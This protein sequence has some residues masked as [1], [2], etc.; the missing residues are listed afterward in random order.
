MSVSWNTVALAALGS[1]LSIGTPVSSVP[2]QTT[3]DRVD[4]TAD[5]WDL[6]HATIVDHLGR[7]AL[8]GTAF[9]KGVELDDGVIECDV[10]MKAD[11]RAYPGVLFRVQSPGE[12]ERVYLRP[13]RAPL[14]DDAVQYV[15]AFNGVD[16]WQLSNGPGRTASAVIPTGRWLHFRIEVLGTQARVYLD[17]SPEPVL[18][19][20]DLGH[21]KSR[22]G[23]GLTTAA[24][25]TAFFSNFSYRRDAALR[26]PPAP[27]IHTP[28]GIVTDWAVSAPFKRKRLDFDRYPEASVLRDTRWTKTT[29]RSDGIL[30][31]SRVQG[32]LGAEPDGILARTTIRA[33]QAGPRKY[34]FGYSDEAGIFLNGQLVFHG[35]SAYRSRDTSFLGI[36]GPF[37]AVSLP[38]RK[39]DNEVLFAIG[40]A[41]GGW[42]LTLQD[43]TAV[44]MARGVERMW[45]TPADFLVPESVA[46]DPG[47]NAFY[48]SNFDAYN[49]SRG[50]PRQAISKVTPDGHVEALEWVSGLFNPTGLAVRDGTL[51]VVERTAVAEIDIASASITTRIP[52]PGA[53]LP[54]D[55]AIAG[56]GDLYVSDSRKNRIYRIAGGQAEEWVS[57]PP[58]SA[59]N[60]VLVHEGRLIVGTNGDGCLKAVDLETKQVGILANLGVG[61]IDGIAADRQGDLLVSHNEGRL[62]RVARDGRVTTVLDTTAIRMSI[63]DFGYAP[64]LDLV[65]IPTFT[66]GRVAAYRLGR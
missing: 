48:V 12:Y 55:I 66:G 64:A 25:G 35:T 10:A 24:D 13:H 17:E 41:S 18:V 27:V 16:S 44:A 30:D 49:P 62:L 47:T 3:A 23:V 63:A 1:F 60:G 15:A 20:G 9:L 11:V 39:G 61:V 4:F 28:P 22:G 54:N 52:L 46:Y 37:D 56:N 7:K 19:I 14:Y 45:A 33:E 50:E 34:W 51:Y 65:V 53:A 8:M 57:G 29:T 2:L 36:V 58:I 42:G 21:G 26:F 32:R 6:E 38:L 5:R 31:I 40:E 43:A 59:P